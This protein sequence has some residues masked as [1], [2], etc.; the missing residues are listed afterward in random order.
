MIETNS[1]VRSNGRTDEPKPSRYGRFHK[2]K[3]TEP[4]DLARPQWEAA[5]NDGLS[6]AFFEDGEAPEA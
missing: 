5:S 4:R 3:A 2:V 6:R 1:P